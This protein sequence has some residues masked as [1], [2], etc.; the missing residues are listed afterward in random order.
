MSI[1]THVL[2]LKTG[3]PA[4]GISLAVYF[5]DQ[6][7]GAY[8]TDADGRCADLLAGHAIEAGDYKFVFD[9]QAYFAATGTETFYKSIPIEF[10]IT[11]PTRHHHVPLL[12]SPFGY[13]TYR[14]S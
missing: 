5:E 8:T 14:G 12:L 2:D 1:S 13:S 3:L 9:V 6:S 4:Q 10:T 11:D 7:L